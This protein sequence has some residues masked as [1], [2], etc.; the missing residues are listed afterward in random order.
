M[1]R[2]VLVTLLLL[3]FV[4]LTFASPVDV[5]TAQHLGIKFLRNNVESLRAFKESKHVLTL[6]DDNGNACLYIFNI[7]DKGFYIVS[8]DDRAKPILAYSDESRF[9]ADNIPEGMSYYLQTYKD[10]ISYVIKNDLDID[11]A[12]AEEWK[13]L[14]T[15]G[16]LPNRGRKSVEPLVDLLW[17]QEYPYNY[18]CPTDS[19]GP[20]GRVY[21]GCVADAMA[22]VMK[23]WNY[24]DAA[25]GEHSYTPPGYPTQSV[26][27]G[28]E[29]QW[30]NMPKQLTVYSSMTEINAVAT[31]MYHCGVS[32]DMQYGYDGSGTYS[33]EVPRA[34]KNYFKY[35]DRLELSFKTAYTKE[36]WENRL[37]DNFDQ[38]FPAIYGGYSEQ[39]GG[40]SFL[41]DGYDEN[42]FFH[43][44]WG[45]SGWCN[46]YFSIDAVNPHTYNFS[47]E[48]SCVFDLIPAF[49]YDAMPSAPKIE[50]SKEN[51][52]A[53]KAII[54][55]TSPE[56]TEK[57]AALT[58]V[59]KLV[60][61]R[62]DVVLHTEN[63][64]APGQV[65][66][67]EDV[68]PDY[69]QYTYYA[70][71]VNEDVR[72]RSSK[73]G[74]QYGPSCEW[75]LICTTSNFQ[76]WNG[77]KLKFINDNGKVFEEFTMTSSATSNIKI[78]L[79][80]GNVSVEWCAPKSPVSSLMIILKDPS[81][82]TVYQYSGSSSGLLESTLYQVDNNC[83]DCKAPSNLTGEPAFKDNVSGSLIKWN[84][85][86]SPSSYNVYRS[87]DKVEYELIATTQ[88][89][90]YFDVVENG[91]Y[92]YR[93]TSDN[94]DCE[95]IPAMT[96]DN[97]NDYVMISVTA[98]KENYINALIYPNP[99]SGILNVKAEGL[100]QIIVYNALGQKML[101]HDV[102]SDEYILDMQNFE[103]GVYMLRLISRHG[104]TTQRI[105]LID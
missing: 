79:P 53:H 7:D 6:S 62:D 86:N 18:Y 93:V 21:A 55:V 36:D 88:E 17:D 97:E 101:I 60:I 41:C 92:Y 104:E 47:N 10:A 20:G 78:P 28:E 94:S 44:N 9:D 74:M 34:M 1:K 45:W 52:Y 32:V 14:K 12:T 72:G 102:D 22:M 25:E 43:F 85:V 51:A 24:P 84:H 77:G 11:A 19:Y 76:G 29:Y 15:R 100:T 35:N 23:H 8:A 42:R 69:D 96:P 31:L 71:A 73:A 70:Y 82:E 67:I 87:N 37:I 89:N 54:S 5:T 16:V 75:N 83:D 90:E 48:Q 80:E 50:L 40:H 98:I 46:G 49:M 63:N 2:K 39:S 56:K 64:P 81:G 27:F 65:V 26:T 66:T 57:G 58:A 33:T 103:R 105:T 59:Q 3:L 95:S 38:G 68:V 99:T 30:E 61:M 91:T 4:N 13:S